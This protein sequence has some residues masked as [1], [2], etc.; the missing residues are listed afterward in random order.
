M[1]L[2]EGKEWFL[3]FCHPL[4]LYM[5]L[6]S[7]GTVSFYCCI[8]LWGWNVRVPY[9]HTYEREREKERKRKYTANVQCSVQ[10]TVTVQ[11]SVQYT[12][13]VQCSVQYT[14]TVQCTV[15]CNCT[16]YCTVHFIITLFNVGNV[17]LCVIYQLNFTV[18]MYVTRISCY[19]SHI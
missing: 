13:T 18:F 7:T 17:L 8:F 3:S 16:L 11:I 12:V 2:F 4:K 1:Q 6:Y 14:V 15:H 19:I 10:Y 5:I 9:F